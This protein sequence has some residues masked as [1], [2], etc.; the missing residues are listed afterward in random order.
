MSSVSC[1][2]RVLPKPASKFPVKRYNFLVPDIFPIKPVS[3]DADLPSAVKK[4]IEKLQEYV[5]K[6]SERAPKVT[7]QRVTQ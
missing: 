2:G 6:N 1:F 3:V 5:S 7:C 4:K